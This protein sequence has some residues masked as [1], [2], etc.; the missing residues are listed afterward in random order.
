VKPVRRGRG[1]WLALATAT[2]MA[3]G[4]ATAPRA[5]VDSADEPWACGTFGWLDPDRTV[6]ILE[7]RIRNEVAAS[8]EAKGYRQVDASPDCLVSA[9]MVSGVRSRSPVSVGVGAGSWGGNVGGSV[10]VSMPVGGARENRSLAIDVVDAARKAEV[11][12]G[13]L[14][15]AFREPDPGAEEIAA[16]VA[17]LLEQFPA[18]GA[19]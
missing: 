9:G 5:I 19:R 13:T 12:R 6:S 11:W 18:R 2:L 10:G 14:E 3:A 1:S 4:C 17:L 8:L 15:G 16:A 7:Q